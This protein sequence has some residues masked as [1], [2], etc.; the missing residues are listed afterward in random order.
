MEQ[1]TFADPEHRNQKRKTLR[2]LFLERR[3]ALLPRSR[4]AERI[5]PFY[6]KAG[7][8]RRP[9]PL[10]VM[11]WAHC[12]QP[13]YNLSDPGMDDHLPRTLAPACNN[14]P[15]K[16]LGYRTPAEIFANEVLHL[17]CEPIFPLSPE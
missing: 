13:C 9:Y 10:A 12:G 11:L 15:R 1:P 2:G 17:K 4:L 5:R 14:P 8:G 3:D 6:P 16:C 7:R